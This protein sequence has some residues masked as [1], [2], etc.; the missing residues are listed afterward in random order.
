ML[1]DRGVIPIGNEFKHV[2]PIHPSGGWKE[3]ES[4]S[5]A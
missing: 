2:S 4:S 1:S 5:K 3:T